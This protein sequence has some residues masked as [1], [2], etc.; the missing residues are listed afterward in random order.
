MYDPE[1]LLILQ[2]TMNLMSSSQGIVNLP[3]D[4]ANNHSAFHVTE[5]ELKQVEERLGGPNGLLIPE[6][7]VQ[8]TF[9]HNPNSNQAHP[10]HLQPEG[11]RNLFF[12]KRSS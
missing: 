9:P 10:L 2:S 3:F 5:S 12:L 7:F 11:G 1:W 4:N 6:N 8:T